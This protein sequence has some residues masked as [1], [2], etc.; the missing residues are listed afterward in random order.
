MRLFIFSLVVLCPHFA[1]AQSNTTVS[2]VS[3]PFNEI[4][5]EAAKISGIQLRGLVSHGAYTDDGAPPQFSVILPQSWGGG[6]FC[7]RVVSSDGLYE[8]ENTYQIPST[9][10]GG[11]A[12]L[13]YPTST[14]G[15]LA[16]LRPEEIAISSANGACGDTSG[17]IAVTFWE[18]A[19]VAD[20]VSLLIN[21]FRAE[22]TYLY[23]DDEPSIPDIKCSV[24]SAAIRASFDTI[25]TIP[26]ALI[27]GRPV[28]ATILPIKNG[29]LGREVSVILHLGAAG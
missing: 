9:W 4:V 5:R 17:E 2:L 10:Q 13:D 28:E 22:E 14:P 12:V 25:C 20:S 15:R 29:E 8:A 11:A 6:V 24:S 26:A 23:F 7:M 1:M 21:A 18:G 3:D 27:R 19:Q 16:A